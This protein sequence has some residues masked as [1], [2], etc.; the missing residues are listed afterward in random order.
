LLWYRLLPNATY[1][2]GILIGIILLCLP[3]LVMLS[4]W[5][6]DKRQQDIHPYR[7]IALSLVLLVFLVGGVIV[8]TKIGGGG[9]LHNLD[10]FI[11]FFL[12]ISVS[13]LTGTYKTEHANHPLRELKLNGF[14]FLMLVLVPVFF[15]FQ[16][17]VVWNFETSR[18]AMGELEKLNQALQIVKD[19]EGKMLFISNRQLQTFHLVPEFELIPEYEKDILMEMAMAKNEPYLK[20]FDEEIMAGRFTAVLVDQLNYNHQTRKNGFGEE[21]NA[22]LDHV[23]LPLADHYVVGY[24]DAGK[25]INLLVRKD[26]TELLDALRKLQN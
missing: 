23:L 25:D 24:S 16:H 8:S 12:L 18:Q 1:R 3:L 22:W 20:T 13:L 21:N 17:L 6:N 5:L 19:N 14:W 2:M 7:L 11:V 26:A 4:K 9:D 15:A 10:A